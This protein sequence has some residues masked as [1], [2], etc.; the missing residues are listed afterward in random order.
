[1]EQKYMIF[2]TNLI[3]FENTLVQ[4]TFTSNTKHKKDLDFSRSYLISLVLCT[5]SLIGKY[6]FFSSLKRSPATSLCFPTC[7]DINS[8]GF[9][10]LNAKRIKS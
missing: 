8:P 6:Q 4:I 1:M 2:H 9:S 5:Y 3:F 7:S 10:S